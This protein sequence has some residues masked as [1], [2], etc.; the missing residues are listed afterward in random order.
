MFET[1]KKIGVP[2][3]IAT[4][5]VVMVMAVPFLFKIDERYAKQAQLEAE[6]LR[7]EKRNQEL[8]VELAQNAGFQSAMIALIQQGRV[9]Q[10]GPIAPLPTVV[11]APAPPSPAA[12]PAPVTVPPSAIFAPGALPPST[13]GS[14]KI[15]KPRTWTEIGDAVK[16]QEQRL[17]K[18]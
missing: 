13:A 10:P 1:L 17:L 8:T 14:S 15:E 9:P 2:T 4:A 12:T 5:I 7:L 18:D 11:P 16:R 3:A 6:I